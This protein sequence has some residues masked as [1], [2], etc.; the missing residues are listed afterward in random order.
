MRT[1]RAVPPAQ[2]PHRE[3]RTARVLVVD[4]T[5]RMLLFSDSDPGLPGSH[6]WITPG[7]GVEPGES[8]LEAAVRELR[9]E[10]GL[11]A[12]AAHLVGPLAT[13]RVAHGYSDVV[14]EQD[15]VFL[16]VAVPPFEVDVSGH[17]E[18]ERL[19]MTRH[20]WWTRAELAGTDERVWPACLLELWDCN[21]DTD[22][23]PLRPR[24]AGGVHGAPGLGDLAGA[25]CR[26]LSR[27]SYPSAAGGSVHR[28]YHWARRSE[29]L[30]P[31]RDSREIS[32]GVSAYDF[33][34]DTLQALSFALFRTYGLVVAA[35]RR[36]GQRQPVRGSLGPRL[37]ER[38]HGGDPAAR[39]RRRRALRPGVRRTR[40]VCMRTGRLPAHRRD[41]QPGR[42]PRRLVPG[43]SRRRADRAADLRAGGPRRWRTRPRAR[44]QLRVRRVP[45]RPGHHRLRRRALRPPARDARPGRDRSRPDRDVGPAAVRPESDRSEPAEPYLPMPSIQ[46]AIATRSS[47]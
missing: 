26:A 29:Q 41:R 32:L 25:P 3:R 24:R 30:D 13:R 43:R 39:G 22:G 9:E 23:A 46:H 10:T 17:T 33:P 11:E 2:R 35:R 27:S 19:T 44:G 34:W 18:E 21:L 47:R 16:G 31:V 7:G 45:G 8:D 28:R 40:R 36:G 5:G 14:V 12:R 15:E 42:D 1:F 6:W 38:V 37:R 4:A 20:R